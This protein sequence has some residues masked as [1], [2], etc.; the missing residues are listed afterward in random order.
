MIGLKKY[1]LPLGMICLSVAILADYFLSA[2]STLS[3]SL[4]ILYGLSIPLN[5]AGIY[6]TMKKPH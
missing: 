6:R 4:G 1:L 2:D 5:I 3:F